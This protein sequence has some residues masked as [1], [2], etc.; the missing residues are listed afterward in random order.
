MLVMFNNNR[1]KVLIYTF[2]LVNNNIKLR[3][4]YINKLRFS[5]DIST[6]RLLTLRRQYDFSL[7][8]L[9]LWVFQL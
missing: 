2:I 7:T 8:R 1:I 6:D 9:T 3:I 4:K 5:K